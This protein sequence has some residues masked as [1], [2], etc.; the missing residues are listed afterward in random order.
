MF[1]FSTSYYHHARGVWLYRGLNAPSDIRQHAC[2]ALSAL[3]AARLERTPSRSLF[4]CQ[5][6]VESRNLA[7]FFALG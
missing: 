1:F 5:V 2:L 6:L 3:S 7:V 4:R